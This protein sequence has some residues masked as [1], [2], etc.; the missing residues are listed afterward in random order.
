LHGY[1][2][3]WR[4]LVSAGVHYEADENDNHYQKQVFQNH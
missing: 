1:D 4:V 2:T 3:C